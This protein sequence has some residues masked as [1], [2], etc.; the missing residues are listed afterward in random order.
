MN[1]DFNTFLKNIYLKVDVIERLEF[2]IAY[3]KAASPVL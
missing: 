3:I 1:W 2:D